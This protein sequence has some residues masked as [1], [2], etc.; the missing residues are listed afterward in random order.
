MDALHAHVERHRARYVEALR[1][2]CRI[3]SVSFHNQA[4]PEA[5]GCATS[6][7]SEVGAA[8]TLRRAEGATPLVVGTIRG[9]SAR[10]LLLYNHYDVVPAEPLEAWST[11]PFAA[12][13][14]GGRLVARGASDNKGD[15]VARL[16]AVDAYR[17]VH[18]TLPLTVKFVVDGEEELGSPH[19]LE[20]VEANRELL[21][22]DIALGEGGGRDE[23]GRPAMSLGCRGRIL[24]EMES[25]G[26]RQTF[27]SSLTS[28]VP[29]PAWDIVW[30]F[31]SMKDRDERI[32]IDGFHDDA[33]QP[34]E[35]ELA[36]LR[37]LRFDGG[38]LRHRLGIPR[39]TLDVG[40]ADAVRRMLFEPTVEVSSLGAGRT[41]DGMKGMPRRA[42]GVVRFGLVPNQVPSKIEP[43]L[44]RHLD[45]HGFD[46][47]AMR[48]ISERYPGKVPLD[49]PLVGVVARVATEFYRQPPVVYPVAPWVGAPYHELAH[50]LNVPL[51]NVGIGSV[52]SRF[53]APDEGIELEDYAKGIEF[54]AR[55]FPALADA[56]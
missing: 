39:L 11:P 33:L 40:D 21:R 23:L 31:A 42:V 20:V 12:E 13:V 9:R 19:L 44:R 51:I 49:H 15:L 48:P 10:T 4:I 29:N 1:A 24:F 28:I 47:I 26:A 16:C 25:L 30:A 43:L 8:V 38:A 18:G 53:H 22:S 41:L 50:P 14:V 3:P 2:L 45:A 37:E 55:L 46:R 17:A 27:H 36:L 5:V 52:E 35:A 54:M 56:A 34:T 6:M 32:T 7:L